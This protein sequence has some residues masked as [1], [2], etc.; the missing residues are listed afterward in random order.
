MKSK[1]FQILFSSAILIFASACAT[2]SYH[3]QS[4]DSWPIRERA[5]V[6]TDGDIR[7]SASVPG[8][9]ET[10]AIFGIPTYTH[11]IQPVWLQIENNGPDR[12]RFAPTGLDSNYFSPLEVSYIHRK[13]FTREARSEMDQRLYESAMP[14][15]IPAGE[16]RSGYVFTNASPGTKSFNVDLFSTEAVYSFTFF[17]AV[18]GFV[19]DHEEIDFHKLYLPEEVSDYDL[20]G[21]RD[22]LSAL[23][24][25][26][27]DQSGLQP[28]LPIGSV[29]VGDGID[30]LRALLRAGWSESSIV[31]DEDQL[32]KAH[33]LFGRKP[34]AVFRIKRNKK[35]DRNEL[36]LWV[37][38]LRVDGKPVWLAQL[39]HFIGKSTQLKQIIFGASFDPNIDDGRNYFLQ[40]I[41]Y[42]QSL[43]KSAWLAINEAVSI[44][45]KRTDFNESSYFTDG[46]VNVTWL[47]TEPVSL[48]EIETVDWDDPPL[49]Q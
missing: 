23:S 27:T 42:S 17:V 26:T 31:H 13:G 44:E 14:R 12:L 24:F 37:A 2:R 38:P 3:Y 47:S 8:E 41:W 15:Q 10:K 40:S 30:V 34:D 36:L 46:Y 35:R 19:P 7:I 25:K 18:P 22:G 33:Y 43:D 39:H 5:V 1:V 28:G 29:I 6:Q 48:I 9:D 49:G 11:G 45:N 16:T 20:T 32:A 21:F 4:T